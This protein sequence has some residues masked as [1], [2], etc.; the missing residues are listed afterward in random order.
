MN[1]LRP[2]QD[3]AVSAVFKEWEDVRSTLVVICTGGGKTHVIAEILKRGLEERG[4]GLVIG[5]RE[6]I[7]YQNRDKII[8][9][10]GLSCDIEMGDQQSLEMLPSKV[11]SATVQTLSSLKRLEK[12]NPQLFDYLIIDEAHHSPAPSYRKL[13]NYFYQNPKLRICGVTATPDRSD[14]E[15]L[16]KVFDSVAFDYEIVTAI[17]EGWLVP[18]E[19][20][21]V[22]INSLDYSKLHTVAG[23][24]NQGELSTVL[25]MEENLHGIAHATL[26]NS[27]SEPTLV[28]AASVAQADRLC[29]IM[30][31]H[32]SSQAAYIV[33]STPKDERRTVLSDFANNQLQ[34]VINV[35]VL[36]EGWD[37]VSVKN[38]IMAR[39]TK[40]RALFAQMAGRGLRPGIDVNPY[41]SS[42]ERKAAITA[43]HKPCCTIIDFVGNSGQHKLM[44]ATDILGG[45]Y[46]EIVLVKAKEN[47]KKAGRGNINE[48]LKRAKVELE[49]EKERRRRIILTADY[50]KYA[51]NPF[52]AFHIE[53][54]RDKGWN[55]GKHLSEKQAGLLLKN[56]F[57][58]DQ[59]SY[60]ESKT[61]LNELFRRW[62]E[63]LAS[64]KQ[65][66]VLKKYGYKGSEQIKFAE[67]SDLINKLAANGWRQ[68]VI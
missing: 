3:A 37:G 42:E 41:F 48:E 62:N 46:E 2:Y 53:P 12:F 25:E 20:F 38:I 64:Y 50:Q 45:N 30:N 13:I 11:I 52:D 19:Q 32:K 5:H 15:A 61:L 39:P 31:R 10:G 1:H 43:S 14:E 67:A 63:K 23:D 55:K 35:G 34:Y 54:G 18:V 58:P 4:R 49:K 36:T 66:A 17:E 6:E 56:G 29:E 40:S 47:I 24:F 27:G 28:F 33:G 44:S 26:E 51:I 68:G 22:N 8:K 65:L 7:V 9:Y 21:L 60:T 16:G 57:N 59:M